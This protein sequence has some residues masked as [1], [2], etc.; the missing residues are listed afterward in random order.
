MERDAGES[1]FGWAVF[2]FPGAYW[3]AQHHAVWRSPAG[4]LLDVTP[5]VYADL[6]T[7]LFVSD[8]A[9]DVDCDSDLPLSCR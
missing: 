9:A 3:E 8:D 1:V 7:T 5:P 6:K 2:A 4:D